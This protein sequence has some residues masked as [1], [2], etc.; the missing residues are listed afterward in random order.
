MPLLFVGA[1]AWAVGTALGLGGAA[2]PAV[3]AAVGV[4]AAAAVLPAAR[5][6]TAGWETGLAALLLFGG[7][8]V[9]GADVRRAD[10]ACAAQARQGR[11]WEARLLT[12]ASAGSFV[13]ARLA[14]C[15][16]TIAVAVRSGEAPAGSL[17]RITGAEPSDG[18]RGLLLRDAALRRIRP[19]GPLARWRS[20]VAL[21]LD[22]RFGT[23]APLVRA[24]LIA[25]T[26]GL[27]PDLR[28]RYT[29]A[30][31]V[32]VLSISGM[33]VAIIGGA[34]LL[35]VEAL[36]LPAVWGR[37]LA[38]A[39]AALYVLAIGAPA[40]AVRS[41][42]LFAATNA[43]RLMQRPVRMWAMFAL[44][45][46]VP[47]VEPRT[48]LDLGWQLSVAG[49]AGVLAAGRLATRAVPD[50]WRG[51]RGT[52]ARELIAGVLTTLATAPLVAW[53][54]GRLSLVAPLS[55]LAAGPIVALLQPTLFLAMLLP[56]PALADLTADAS[57]PMLRA[58]DAVAAG[59]ASL[60]GA[61]VGVAPTALAALLSGAA[62][63]AVIV[64][65]SR[66]HWATPT[67][68]ALACV[69]TLVWF[70]A[71]RVGPAGGLEVH[72]IDVGQGDAVALRTP[73]GR[74]ILVDAGRTW[75][76]GDAGRATVIPYLRRVGG[77][78]AL[79]VLTHPHADHVGGAASVIGALRPAAVRDAAFVAGSAPYAAML[80]ETV[81]RGAEWR[82]VRPGERLTIDAVTLDFLA[83]DS[84]W[85]VH[86]TDPNAA[87]TVLR[88]TFGAVHV[89]LTGDAE[90]D[91][92]AWLL[93][94]A[95]DR[96]AATVLKVGHHG[97][98]T[99]TT[100]AFLDA[101]A[102][103]LALVSVGAANSYGH[104]APEVMARLTARGATVL[105]TDQL[106]S[107]VVRT[108]GRALDV[109]AAGHRWAL[110]SPLPRP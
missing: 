3:V 32:H 67:C 40:P 60:P 90:A 88:V 99:S 96:L 79:F 53:H 70:P 19:P 104:P 75:S 30:G 23:D 16:L 69:A 6:A 110:A 109:E 58:L 62:V 42:T 36:R 24:L 61:A 13:R 51:W 5:A 73:R 11:A 91:E 103:R 98:R 97:S 45:A 7:G 44:G 93:R 76:A 4:L 26:R 84:A 10:A 33:H 65:A 108:D 102:P 9:L 94:H 80:R 83:P 68:L 15:A 37:A 43:A 20:R 87:S 56:V 50:S 63:V 28:E 39:I 35:G 29:D 77:P 48:V 52:L 95:G 34:L 101:V 22:A 47:L 27:A 107:V 82:R 59:A 78:L 21:A 54:F 8:A 31:L 14:D 38:V 89:L 46:V 66:R 86:L 74:W 106:G 41:V 17:V 71:P 105:R 1:L 72:L 49:Y 85:T 2:G 57:R 64:A 25:D 55:N 12:D 92:E 81:R 100:P 18:E